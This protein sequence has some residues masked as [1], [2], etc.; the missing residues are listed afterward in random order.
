MMQ[1]AAVLL[2]TI[3]FLLAVLFGFSCTVE[4]GSPS[5]EGANN[6]NRGGKAV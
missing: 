4:D 1:A 2:L 6:G 5:R 3:S